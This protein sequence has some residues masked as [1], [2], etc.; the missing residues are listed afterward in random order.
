MV[1]VPFILH[2]SV[3]WELWCCACTSCSRL[4]SSLSSGCRSVLLVHFPRAAQQQSWDEHLN[5]FVLPLF[6]KWRV[7]RNTF[8]S[9]LR[10]YYWN[11]CFMLLWHLSHH[12]K[13]P[14]AVRKCTVFI[15]SSTSSAELMTFFWRKRSLAQLVA[16]AHSATGGFQPLFL[17]Q[18]LGEV[19]DT[20]DPLPIWGT[21]V[22]CLGCV[23]QIFV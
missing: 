15:L 16:G 21:Q 8:I 20:A 11:S 10:A 23:W 5:S 7:S 14:P 17:K 18:S 6:K 12:C 4:C 9:W 1:C 2:L 22:C 13:M 3:C 19:A